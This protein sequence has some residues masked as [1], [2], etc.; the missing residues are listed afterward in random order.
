MKKFLFVLLITS[1][2]FPYAQNNYEV[3]EMI[4]EKSKSKGS[5]F[6]GID[7]NGYIYTIAIK[8]YTSLL[9]GPSRKYLKV[10]N[11]Q[12]GD[13]ISE[14][15]ISKAKALKRMGLEYVSFTFIKER[16]TVVCKLKG[17]TRQEI[18]YGFEV[19]ENGSFIGGIFELG[20]ASDC[21]GFLNRGAE[22]FSGVEVSESKDGRTTFISDMSCRKDDETSYKLVE[23]DK[24]LEVIASLN[25]ELD[26]RGLE[27][28]DFISLSDYIYFKGS[29]T[30][31]EKVKGKLFRQSVK[32]D[33]L[34]KIDKKSGE[35]YE[36]ALME[37][38]EPLK[39]GDYSISGTDGGVQLIGQVLTERGFT[40][41]FSAILDLRTDEVK[42]IKTQ[43][44]SEEFVTKYWT[45]KKKR[46]NERKKRRRNDDDEEEPTGFSTRFVLSESF[47]TEDNGSLLVFQQYWIQVVTRT[48]TNSN[49]TTT[50]TTD[51]YYYYKDVIVVKTAVDGTIEYTELLPFFQ[52]TMNFDPGK[53]YSALLDGNEIYFLHGTS[54]EMDEMINEGERKQKKKRVKFKDRSIKYAS[55]THL[56]EQGTVETE[57]VINM[58]EADVTVYNTT[59]AVDTK[60]KQ[61]VIVSPF[62][63]MFQR[64]KTKV[65]RIE[66]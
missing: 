25:F 3:T 30:T 49:G 21:K 59:T 41:I 20:E 1:W 11:A 48:S 62:Q 32:Q 58:G 43:D 31:N 33:Y 47:A 22:T 54:N 29:K 40:G 56:D 7:E 12:T 27:D 26:I 45:E 36:L 14:T 61:F 10:F 50:T 2:L 46:K 65:V 9:F 57:Q 39:I 35:V 15:L 64:K 51:Y 4:A 60:N 19:D 28:I 42:D 63:K 23:L 53:G 6:E 44:F 38:I 55:V 16:P 34:Y 8:G 24:D 37:A 52:V 13:M 17:K 5:R 66:L 18:F